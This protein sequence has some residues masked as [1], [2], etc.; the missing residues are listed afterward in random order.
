MTMHAM[1]SISSISSVA[2]SKR[3]VLSIVSPVYRA[4]GSV[5][6]L[7]RRIVAAISPLTDDFEIV[8]VD[9]RSPDASWPKVVE[10]AKSEPRVRGVRLARNFGQHAAITAAL[11]L[12]RGETIV[13][14][15]CDLQHAPEEIPRM[16]EKLTEGHDIVLARFE[17]RQHA[18]H[19]NLG[20]TAWRLM[21][22]ALSGKEQV[23]T[24]LGTFSML[25]RPVVDAFL[26]FPEIHRHYLH[27]LRW[28]GFRV[29]Y[30]DVAHQER[31][32]GR[33][34][35]TFVKL[36]KHAIVG[37]VG[38]SQRILYFALG[39]GAAFCA[40]ALIGVVW[41]VARSI[42]YG[43]QAG[44]A[45]VVVLI[46]A[47]TGVIL[48]NLGI[49]GLYIGSIFDQVRGRPIYLIGETTDTPPDSSPPTA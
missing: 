29:A 2:A 42:L 10:V 13:V 39:L 32:E 22:T 3:P 41:V 34:S 16:W 47:S 21:N 17:E 38:Q 36:L 49:L 48:F 14:M 11:E 25:T 27:I 28:M 20:A 30:V 40:L 37:T 6:E 43:S 44:W 35:Y 18:R 5:A 8:L 23:P 45:S 9:D 1:S 12:A 24:N 15:D 31:Y 4:E 33:S 19:R 26:R 46:L 7:V